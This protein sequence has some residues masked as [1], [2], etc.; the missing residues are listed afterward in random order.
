MLMASLMEV[1]RRE[2][3][4]AEELL[5][6]NDIIS[7]GT[8]LDALEQEYLSHA[9][10]DVFAAEP[11]PP[12]SALWAH[13]NVTITP[14]VAAVSYAHDVAAVFVRNLERWAQGRP[15]QHVVDWR[16]GY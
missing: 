2:L 11:L 4:T 9:V 16:T 15:L 1:F 12:S 8:L 3:Q 6:T 14:H 5:R 13:D 10:L 7:E